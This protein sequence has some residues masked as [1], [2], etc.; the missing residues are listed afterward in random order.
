MNK[1]NKKW[2]NS[3]FDQY[4]FRLL[5]ALELLMSFT[6]L[7]YI[8]IPPISIT[9]AYIPIII[10][11]CL[12]TPTHSALMGFIF[13]LGSLYKASASYVMPADMIFSPFQSGFPVQSLLLSVGTRTLFGF[14]I[15]VLFLLMRKK[16]Y[17][18]IW[19]G[20]IAFIAPKFHSFLV[21]SAMGIFFPSLGYNYTFAFSIKWTDLL[22]AILCVLIVEILYEFF[23]TNLLKNLK[24]KIDKSKDIIHSSKII[25]I[26]LFIFEGFSFCMSLF[27]T[28]YFWERAEY[29]LEQYEVEVT[30][31]ISLDI[32]HL[33]AQFLV[34]MVA[35][36]FICI[37]LLMTVY[38]YMSYREYM[39]ELDLLTG[40]MGRR[41]FLQYCESAQH[42][43]NE[44]S[45]Q[46]GW[47]LFVDVDYFKQ[48]NDTLGHSC[49]DDV[50]RDIATNLQNTFDE[51]GKVGRFGGDEFA[52]MLN[53]E[54]SKEQL[55]KCLSNFLSKISTI[56]PDRKVS[57]SI[58]A[59]AFTF[60]QEVQHLLKK[61]DEL[62][63]Q[64]K[65][66][67]KGCFV[68]EE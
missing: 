52:A 49:G 66:N 32:L 14:L 68:I 42:N 13:G 6:F 1:R 30:K 55:E 9:I 33:Q 3:I 58:G 29:M 20:I 35:L 19:N 50:L 59:Y 12:L 53:K 46:Q 34:S 25:N 63:Y 16:K 41:M 64:A 10:T 48:I 57:C 31:L 2:R 43:I 21:Y 23:N 67:G 40:V 8:H 24:H 51:Y 36:N 17:V 39:N 38:R 27:A 62:L 45:K 47:F 22:I 56:L 28:I 61:T 15:G 44:A 60:P 54:I 7:G 11:G 18:R 65:E 5:I 37:L 4:T 26:L